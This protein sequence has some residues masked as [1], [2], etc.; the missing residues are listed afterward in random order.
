MTRMDQAEGLEH[1]RDQGTLKDARWPFISGQLDDLGLDPLTFRV[2]AR[3]LRRAS[4]QRSIHYESVCAM[5][6]GC[7]MSRRSVQRALRLLRD[8]RLLR[9]DARPGGTTQYQPVDL[10]DWP[11]PAAVGSFMSDRARRRN[12][13]RCA[14]ETQGCAPGAQGVRL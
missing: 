3:I 1:A 13:S 11:T 8:L 10:E 6:K 5:G 4:S 14:R 9:V 12:S 7:G 2:F